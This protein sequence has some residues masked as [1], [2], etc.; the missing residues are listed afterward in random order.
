MKPCNVMIS[1][2]ADRNRPTT[3]ERLKEIVCSDD[4]TRYRDT[5]SGSTVHL[6][7]GIAVITVPSDNG[8]VAI[9]TAYPVHYDKFKRKPQYKRVEENDQKS[10]EGDA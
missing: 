3:D 1:S 5:R 10:G 7:D 4:A 9:K 2:H 6:E 8:M